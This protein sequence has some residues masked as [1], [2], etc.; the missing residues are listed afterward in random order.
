MQNLQTNILLRTREKIELFTLLK[1]VTRNMPIVHSNRTQYSGVLCDF[2]GGKCITFILVLIV[3]T[4]AD[5]LSYYHISEY[6]SV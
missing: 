4:E 3:Y 6:I 5:I 2:G 1:C